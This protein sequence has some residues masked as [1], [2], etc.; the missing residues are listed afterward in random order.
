[1]DGEHESQ[2]TGGADLPWMWVAP[3]PEPVAWTEWKAEEEICFFFRGLLSLPLPSD[4]ILSSEPSVLQRRLCPANSHQGLQGTPRL[5]TFSC[6]QVLSAVHRWPLWI[7]GV[8]GEH[9][10]MGPLPLLVLG[11]CLI[12]P[13]FSPTCISCRFFPLE[14]SNAMLISYVLQRPKEQDAQANV[15]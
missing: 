11:A 4:V 7:L 12:N 14:N 1:M 13:L 10:A 6:Y 8:P 5:S 3:T 15:V 9:T 2:H